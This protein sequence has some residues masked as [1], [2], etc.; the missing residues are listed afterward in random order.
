MRDTQKSRV[1]AAERAAAGVDHWVQ[2]IP[3][4]ELQGWVDNVLARRGV[5]AR[6][7]R[8]DIDVV[9]KRGGSAYSWGGRITLPKG[10][11]NPW[12][13]LHEIAHE[14]TRA[15]RSHGPEFAGVYLYLVRTVIGDDAGK[16]IL[17][18]YREHRVRR[19][20]K[21]IPK[22]RA[23]RVVTKT[24]QAERARVARS[25]PLTRD[26]RASAARTIRRAVAAGTF[27]PAG[28]KPR[29]HALATARALET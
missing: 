26:E 19:N 14:L 18:A 7:G 20:T 13:V 23:E 6:W 15:T 21:G 1:Y 12:V 4:G 27:G 10:A 5:Q 22:P 8:C 3:N 16:A 17:A 2:T 28:R 11:R 25:K 24:R 29:T 9:L